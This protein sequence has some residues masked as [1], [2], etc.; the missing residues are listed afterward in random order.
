M[1]DEALSAGVVAQ[2]L[3]VAVTTLRTWHQRYGLGPSQHVPGHHRRYTPADLARLEVMR[4]LTAEGV[5]PAEA[6]RW[7]RQAPDALAP[8][9]ISRAVRRRDGGGTTIPVGRAGPAARGL[10]RAAMRLDAA[11]ISE[12]IGRAIAADGVVATWDR[13][14]RPLLVGI[15]ERHAATG[16]LIEVE[17]LVTR[18]ISAAFSVAASAGPAPGTPR[19]LL[20]CAD[21]EQHSLPLEA[22][23]AALAEAGVGY[24]MLGARVPTTALLAAIDRTGPAAVVLW[25]Q[26]RATA[27]P[28]QLTALLTASSRPMLVLAAGPGWPARAL[29]TG[30]VHPTDLTEAVSL[31]VA[32]HDSLN[33]PAAS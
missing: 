32:L 7:A 5:S 4:R 33:R 6:A 1:A 16:A 27:D 19:V 24:R 11:A 29:P 10:A 21:E 8:V 3:G 13:L 2:R 18:C 31:T 22:L 20:S 15:G 23:A 28:A 25:S 9:D 30:V 26:T 17:H 12:T 14:L